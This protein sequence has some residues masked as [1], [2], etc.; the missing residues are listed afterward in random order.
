[1]LDAGCRRLSD[2]L[3][4]RVTGFDDLHKHRH[5]LGSLSHRGE[6]LA[7]AEGAK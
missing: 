1:M 3:R 6:I 4:F 7:P 5:T 2:S